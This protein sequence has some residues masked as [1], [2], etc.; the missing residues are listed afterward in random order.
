MSPTAVTRP[1]HRVAR[2]VAAGFVVL[3]VVLAIAGCSSSSDTKGSAS[4][5]RTSTPSSTPPSTRSGTTSAPPVPLCTT[6]AATA[7]LPSGTRATGIIC[8][9]GWAAGPDTD[10]RFDAAYLLRGDNGSWRMLTATEMQVA[11]GAGNAMS[12]PPGVLAQSPCTVS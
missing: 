6:D 11:C 2:L 8:S 9:G 1:A 5:E 12:I 3:G 4:T 7:A 10:G